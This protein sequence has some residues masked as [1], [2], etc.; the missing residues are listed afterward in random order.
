[1]SA[2]LC[3]ISPIALVDKPRVVTIVEARLP[4]QPQPQIILTLILRNRGILGR[5]HM[6]IPSLA[7]RMKRHRRG[8]SVSA[9]NRW[10]LGAPGAGLVGWDVEAVADSMGWNLIE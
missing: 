6:A 10:D 9:R 2:A 3:L 5:R 4:L 7:I 1:M 8:R